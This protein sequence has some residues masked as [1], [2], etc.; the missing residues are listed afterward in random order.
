[1][2]LFGDEVGGFWTVGGEICGRGRGTLREGRETLDDT[3]E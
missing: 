2:V 3:R 1:M